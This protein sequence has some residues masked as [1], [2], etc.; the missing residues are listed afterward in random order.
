MAHDGAVTI[1][2]KA[3]TKSFEEEI[4]Q[5]EEYLNKLVSAYEKVANMKGKLKP[6][7]QAM[8]N[9]RREIEK[10]NN[11]LIDCRNS[12][13]NLVKVLTKIEKFRKEN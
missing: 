11:K 1:E 6:N 13:N 8:A 9:L 3:D 2:I 12:I 4:K 10:T 5:T 7:E